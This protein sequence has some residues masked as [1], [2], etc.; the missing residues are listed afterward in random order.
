MYINLKMFKLFKIFAF[1]IIFLFF[2]LTYSFSSELIKKIKVKGN[3]RIPTSTVLMFADFKINNVIDDIKINE[4]LKNIYDSN[5]FE[6]VSVKVVKDTLEINVL[7][8]PIIENI[9]FEGLKAKK[10][11]ELV[12]KNLRLKNRSSFNKLLLEKDTQIMLNSLKQQGY[13][14]STIDP[15]IEDLK[16][17]KVNIFYKFNLGKKAKI[18]NISFIGDKVFKDSKLRS[19]ILSE[20]YKFWKFI[21]G[22]KFLNEQLIEIDKRLIKNFYLNSGYFNVEVNSSFA[23]LIEK[24][25]FELVYSINAK[26]KVFFD[27][28]DI[29]YPDDFNDLNFKDLKNLFKEI[30]GKPYSLNTVEKILNEIDYITINDEYRSIKATVDE[31]LLDN[32]LNINFNIEE[33][34]KFFVERINIYGNN[35]TRES[36]IRNQLE[37]DEGDIFNEI[38]NKKSV[39]NLKNLNYFK[40][41]STEVVDGREANA[42]IINFNVIEKPTGDIRAGAGFGTSGGTFVFGIK[43]NNYLGKG[44]A[45]EA[46]GTL[47][48]ESFKGLVKVSNPNFKNSDKRVFASVQAQELDRTST[49][50]YKSNKTGFELGTGFEYLRDLNLGLSTRSFYEKIETTSS[51]SARQKKQEGDYWDTFVE[52]NFD[53]DK[54]NQKFKPTDGYRSFYSFDVPLIS[55][56]NTLTNTISHRYYSQY[57]DN[58]VVSVSMLLKTANS[59]TGDDVKLSERLNVP[60]NRLRGFE[61]GKVGPKDGNDFIGGN[62]LYAL[63]ATTTIPQLF[64]NYQ[65]LDLSLFFDAANVW[66]IDYDSSLSDSS[67]IR[68]SVG[69]GVDLFTP[70]GPMNFSLAETITKSDS[71]IT[72]S[73][74]FSIGTTF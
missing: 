8:F 17:N 23:K 62:Y 39:N 7:E 4:I 15:F 16:E 69:I 42:K 53:L 46:N 41:V 6:N 57:F 50:G 67:K 20:E 2:S 47:T 26:Q 11:I 19:I 66:G 68:S 45:L 1:L 71:D 51:A 29:S 65:N 55:E 34:E 60:S 63:N 52:F 5:F 22:K 13:Y 61:R 44:I 59:I 35:V 56:N 58:N 37:I 30:K 21:S 18:K 24:D 49:Y 25:S 3:D 43:E 73:F 9:F 74:R 33:T 64:Q 32:K 31:Q 40:N 70:V 27:K 54:R 72:E 12:K 36:V 14:F 28:V 48:E 10:N 38:L